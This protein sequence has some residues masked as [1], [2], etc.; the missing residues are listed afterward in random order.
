MSYTRPTL[1]ELQERTISDIEASVL[2]KSTILA[3][4]V[5][6][7][8]GRVL[9]G[10]MHL[11][12]GYIDWVVRQLFVETADEFYLKIYAK[13]YGITQKEASFASGSITLTGTSGATI[14]AEDA[15]FVSTNELEYQA[16]SDVVI[17]DGTATITVNCLTAG[18][19]GNISSGEVF[20]LKNSVSGIDSEAT[21]ATGGI[22]NG[23]DKEDVE[24]LRQRVLDRIQN[25]PHGGNA[26]DYV[27][28]AKEITGVSRAWCIPLYLGSGTVGLTFVCDDL[29]DIIPNAAKIE[30]VYNYVE[31]QRPATAKLT[32]FAPVKRTIDLT[33]KVSP[34]SDDIK[35]NILSELKAF[36]I[37][38]GYPG[39]TLYLS[40]FVQT[41]SN[42][43]DIL[44]CL[45]VSPTTNIVLANNEIA[46]L[47]AIT[48]QTA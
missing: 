34:V 45:I 19:D 8:I 5:L 6:K 9:A 23:V 33:L 40:Q 7:V 30:E 32:V 18:A 10:M 44:S 24:D 42:A 29:T 17:L 47:G 4:S 16:E 43:D 46:V 14:S 38:N 12:Y 20:S 13:R 36:F 11:G 22:T 48:W 26:N 27:Q 41:I 28:W 2:K 35:A 1:K 3:Y 39:N 15:I 21:V 31:T 25:P 37:E